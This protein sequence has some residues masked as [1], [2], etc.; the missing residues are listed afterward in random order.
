MVVLVRIRN[1]EPNDHVVDEGRISQLGAK[2]SK[3]SAH[4]EDEFV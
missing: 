4:A 3:I 1:A 2:R